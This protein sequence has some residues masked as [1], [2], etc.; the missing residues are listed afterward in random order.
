PAATVISTISLHDALP[1]LFC[2]RAY[3]KCGL[4]VMDLGCVAIHAIQHPMYSLDFPGRFKWIRY[5]ISARCL[6]A[7]GAQSSIAV[8]VALLIDRK[9]TRLNS[10]HLGISYA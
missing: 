8:S 10:S 1:I 3:I 7:S 9:S 5:L 2:H 4:F 6:M